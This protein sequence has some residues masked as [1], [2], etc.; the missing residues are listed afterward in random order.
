MVDA[1]CTACVME[2]SSQSL[3]LNRVYG[4]D[5]NIGVFTNFSEDHISPKEH[6]D[7]E[8]YF[9][10]KVELFKMCK[11]GYIN[12]DDINTIRVPKLVPNCMIQTYGIDNENNLLAKDI[13]ITNSYVDFKVKLNGKK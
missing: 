9:N 5:F 7:M 4:S 12:V 11:Y 10:S 1:G 3:K 6:P 2:V 8:D 13:T